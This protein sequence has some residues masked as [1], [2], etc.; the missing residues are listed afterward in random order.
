MFPLKVVALFLSLAMPGWAVVRLADGG[1]RVRGGERAWLTLVAGTGLASLEALVLG[2]LSAFGRKPFILTL[3]LVGAGLVTAAAVRWWK[4]GGRSGEPA[5]GPGWDAAVIVLLVLLGLALFAPPWRIVSGFSDVGIYPAMAANL[6]RE[7]RWWVENR[8]ATEIS[9]PNVDLVYHAVETEPGEFVYHENQFYAFQD[10]GSGK[11][12]PL[13]FH[14][15]PSLLAA[16]AAFLGLENMFWALTWTA[17][18]VLWGIFVHSRRLLGE[19]WAWAAVVLAAVCPVMIYFGRYTGSEMMNALLF[20]G[21][22]LCAMEYLNRGALDRDIQPGDLRH[23]EGKGYGMA[24]LSGFIFSL[25]FLC[26]I[27]FLFLLVPLAIFLILKGAL[28]GIGGP[29]WVLLGTVFLGAVFCVVMG[30]LY[31]HVY[32]GKIWNAFSRRWAGFMVAGGTA[33]AL[34]VAAAALFPSRV[35]RRL[36]E[37]LERSRRF[38]APFLWV[39]LAALFG[40]LYFIRPLQPDSLVS[41]GFIKAVQGPSYR[42]QDFLRWSWYLSPLGVAALFAGYALCMSRTRREGDILLALCGFS[43]TLLYATNMRALPLHVLMMRRLVPVILPVGLLMVAMVLRELAG[44]ADRL[45]GRRLAVRAGT[46]GDPEGGAHGTGRGDF[47]VSLGEAIS[48]EWHAVEEEEKLRVGEGEVEGIPGGNG[49]GSRENEGSRGGKARG[50]PAHRLRYGVAGA[51]VLRAAVAGLFL[52][53]VAYMANASKPLWGIDE[54]GNQWEAVEAVAGEVPAGGILLMDYH[55]GDHFGPPLRNFHGVENAWLKEGTM[56]DAEELDLLL[57]DLGFPEREVYLLWR[58]SISGERLFLPRGVEAVEVLSF[59]VR[60]YALERS[61][62]HR[63]R[64]RRNPLEIYRVF[65]LEASPAALR[66]KGPTTLAL[67]PLPRNSALTR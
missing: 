48:R 9:P 39:A 64:E 46:G 24:V 6:V 14:L 51:W 30:N 53:L 28:R 47:P 62:E 13:F 5:V 15:W 7:G 1:G 52:Y 54:G 20:L 29:D 19:R 42:S 58:P 65:R 3:S 32:F 17:V 66:D 57:A 22:A 36:R 40:W 34:L 60:E 43:F 11:E 61:F 12:W 50:R 63:P 10:L 33:L 41:Y 59:P 8:A 44:A 37:A 45:E 4:R 23:G 55:S 16:F 56:F 18:L 35:R 25:G 26:R 27:D 38:W 67:H 21:G 49:G 31:A 2:Y